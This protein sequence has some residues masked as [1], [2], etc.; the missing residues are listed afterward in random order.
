MEIIAKAYRE[1][2]AASLRMRNSFSTLHLKVS[3]LR[4]IPPA[5]ERGKANLHLSGVMLHGNVELRQKLPQALSI[6]AV[7]LH[8]ALGIRGVERFASRPHPRPSTWR[9]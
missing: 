2:V 9:C 8:Q 1:L 6:A 4:E 3:G 5:S 7:L